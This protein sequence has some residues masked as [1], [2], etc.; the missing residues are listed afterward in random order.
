VLNH[1]QFCEAFA[2][3]GQ[4]PS[5]CPSAVHNIPSGTLTE[6]VR[7][8][9]FPDGS[10]G[11]SSCNNI[12]NNGLLSLKPQSPGGG[13]QW[14]LEGGFIAHTSL[15]STL[16]EL[17]NNVCFNRCDADPDCIASYAEDN[18]SSGSQ[19]Y[20]CHTFYHSDTINQW[21]HWCGHD[22]HKCL[23][24]LGFLQKWSAICP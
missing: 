21:E 11:S 15:V 2:T 6:L 16:D 5:G 20:I 3:L 19:V 12:P 18:S 1:Q 24:Q 8:T 13:Y 22:Q 9:F 7:G 4:Y 10:G 23:S 14:E 17:D